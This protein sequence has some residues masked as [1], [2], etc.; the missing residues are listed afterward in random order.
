[1]AVYHLSI[2]DLL[3]VDSYKQAV[4]DNDNKAM[5]KALF[6]NGLDI[7]KPFTY[8]ESTHRNL[9]GKVVTCERIVGEERRDDSWLLTGCASDQVKAEVR[10]DWSLLK[11]CNEMGATRLRSIEGMYDSKDYNVGYVGGER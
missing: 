2:S 6:V 1:M 3:L 8:E 4:K 9:Q 5:L 10:G 11:D 7:T